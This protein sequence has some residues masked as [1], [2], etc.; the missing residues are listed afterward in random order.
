MVNINPNR[1]PNR[2]KWKKGMNNVV[3]ELKAT[4]NRRR[5]NLQKGEQYYEATGQNTRRNNRANANRMA[6]YRR[7]TNTANNLTRKAAQQRNKGPVLG[8][9]IK[10][11]GLSSR[12]KELVCSPMNASNTYSCRATK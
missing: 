10:V 7:G 2:N 8:Q 1:N 5:N 6:L 3:G 11:S 9:Y 4:L 12:S